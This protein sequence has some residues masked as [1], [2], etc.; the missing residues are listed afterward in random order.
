MV[1]FSGVSASAAAKMYTVGNDTAH[2]EKTIQGCE[3]LIFSEVG[4]GLN[5]TSSGGNFALGDV[6]AFKDYL[7]FTEGGTAEDRKTKYYTQ[8]KV[9][10][11]IFPSEYE[12]IKIS[13]SEPVTN[14]DGT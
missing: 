5:R 12:A 10:S 3:G 11:N 14:D 9:I 13:K 4:D 2:S 8:V 7:N 1:R 6:D